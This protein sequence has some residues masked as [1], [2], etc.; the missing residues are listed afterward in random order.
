MDGS[1]GNPVSLEDREEFERLIMFLSESGRGPL[2]THSTY[3]EAESIVMRSDIVP[4]HELFYDGFFHSHLFCTE[5]FAMRILKAGCTGVSFVDPSRLG[6]GIN[7]RYRT[8]RGIEERVG[9]D[10][11]NKVEI[12]ELI[13]SIA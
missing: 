5:A 3:V 7:R 13:Q 9:W 10:A 6:F 8:L 4:A 12:T 1:I 2:N 11:V